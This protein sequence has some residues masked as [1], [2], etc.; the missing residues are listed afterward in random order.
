MTHG[1]SSWL[2][3][4]H[5]DSWWLIMTHGDS[6]WLIMIHGDS[7][8]LMVSYFDGVI[9]FHGSLHIVQWRYNSFFELRYDYV[10]ETHYVILK[11][12]ILM[13]SYGI[14]GHHILFYVDMSHFLYYVMMTSWLRNIKIISSSWLYRYGDSYCMNHTNCLIKTQRKLV[15]MIHCEKSN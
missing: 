6:S 4:T 15:A 9:G 10:I 1:T 12:V 8:W 13:T 11:W 2:M 14:L 3:V 5:H 7:S